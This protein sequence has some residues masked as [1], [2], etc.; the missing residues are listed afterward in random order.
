MPS[1]TVVAGESGSVRVHA[2]SNLNLTEVTVSDSISRTFASVW[3]TH[4]EARELSKAL[5]AVL[6]PD[7]RAIPEPTPAPTPVVRRLRPGGAA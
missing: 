5:A 1:T 7:G 4:A 2:S 6:W 3:L